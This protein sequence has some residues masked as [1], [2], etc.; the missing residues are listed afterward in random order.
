MNAVREAREVIER[1]ITMTSALPSTVTANEDEADSI[2]EDIE[3][4]LHAVKV[5]RA[6]IPKRLNEVEAAGGDL[7][8]NNVRK[9]VA[10]LHLEMLPRVK[11]A[12]PVLS[13]RLQTIQQ[14]MRGEL[15][16]PCSVCSTCCFCHLLKEMLGYVPFFPSGT[17]KRPAADSRLPRSEADESWK[18]PYTAIAF[19]K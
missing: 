11:V 7:L 3:A 8:L 18:L 12:I 2:A 16:S 15:K 14:L 6:L 4:A 10:K 17:A 5:V 19:E 1:V 13:S 9:Y